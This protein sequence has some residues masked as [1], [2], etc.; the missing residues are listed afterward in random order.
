ML[1]LSAAPYEPKRPTVHFDEASKQLVA[2]T[3]TPLPARPGQPARDDY[4]YARTGTR[5][6]FLF[7]EPQAG[8]RQ[9]HVIA[10]RTQLDFA[11]QRQWLVEE[12]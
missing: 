2:E 12:R 10:H 5:N 7:V 9:L 11:H 3:R 4:E 8:W 6:L 1:E